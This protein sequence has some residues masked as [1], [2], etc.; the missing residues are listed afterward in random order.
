MK[1]ILKTLALLFLGL[2][3]VLLVK[4]FLVK[5]RQM[6]V[7]TV[8]KIPLDTKL[9]TDHISGALR[10]QTI[11]YDHP[12]KI[13]PLEFLR[14][15]EYLRETFPLVHSRLTLEKVNQYSLLFRWEGANPKPGPLVLMAHMDVVPVDGTPW[16]HPPFD[17]VIADSYIWGRGTL[18]DKSCGSRSSKRLNIC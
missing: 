17:G 9:L 3:V 11:S 14:F 6:Q 13:N 18:D 7:T 4:T 5:S 8:K 2:F 16:S 12:E 10:I 15:H 1:T